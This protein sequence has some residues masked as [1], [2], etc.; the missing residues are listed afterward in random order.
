MHELSLMDDLVTELT[1]SLDGARVH[2]VRLELG[3]LSC[4]SPHALEFCFDVCAKGTPMES[5][6]LVIV[7]TDGDALRLKDIEVS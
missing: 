1:R 5:A 3:R 2:V 4:A 6:E 7:R